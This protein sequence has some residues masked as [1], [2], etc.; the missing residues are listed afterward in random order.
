MSQNLIG[1][2]EGKTGGPRTSGRESYEI[3]SNYR[4]PVHSLI[5]EYQTQTVWLDN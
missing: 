2:K 3:S 4:I 1:H 5:S